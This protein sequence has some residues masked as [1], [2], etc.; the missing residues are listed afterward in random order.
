VIEIDGSYGE[1]GGQ[2]LRTA[3]ALSCLLGKP[4]R[5]FDIR[6][7]RKKPGLMPQHLT[8]VKAA[9]L[10]SGASCKGDREGSTELLFEPKAVKPGEYYFDI[11]TAGSTSLLAQTLLLPLVMSRGESTVTLK[12]GTHVPWSPPFH[13]IKE[14]LLPTLRRLGINITAEIDSYG[15]YP[16]GGGKI[17]FYIK[18]CSRVK[19]ADLTHRGNILHIKGISAVGNLPVSIAQRQKDSLLE[20][21]KD[22]KE[23]PMDIEIREVST[24]GQGTFVFLCAVSENSVSGF[25]ALGQRGKR[26]EAVGEE[27][28]QAFIEYYNS[29]SC[30]DLHMADQILPYLAVAEGSSRFTTQR[31]TEHLK[32]N[33]WVIKKFL[34]IHYSIDTSSRE[35]TIEGVAIS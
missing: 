12:G 6:K 26:A 33:F 14:A 22:M 21:L 2:I 32:T 8:C 10:I 30:L 31:L 4:F 9:A 25:S 3:L 11:G 20:K 29:G 23:I 7:G 35:V 19:P 15:F 13:Y 1:G 5:I 28:A 24:P 27:A 17:Q 34:D 18:P 16:K